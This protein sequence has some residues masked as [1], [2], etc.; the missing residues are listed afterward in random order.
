MEN[1]EHRLITQAMVDFSVL[2]AVIEHFDIF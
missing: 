1:N 2:S